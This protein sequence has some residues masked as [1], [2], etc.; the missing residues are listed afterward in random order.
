VCV[1][2]VENRPMFLW[3]NFREFYNLKF[4]KNRNTKGIITLAAM[5]KDIYYL[6]QAFYGSE[7][8]VLHLC[9]RHHFL[10]QTAPDNGIKVY[11]NASE[12][13][14]VLNGVS[15]GKLKNGDYRLAD[16]EK[17]QRGGTV[18]TIPGIQVNNVFFWK[19]TLR[20]GCNVVEVR[21]SRGLSKSMVIYQK[22]ADGP[23]PVDNTALVADLKS[24]N[25]DNPAVFIDR[26]VES[27]GPFYYDVDGSSDNTFD[28][29]PP[30]V[31]GAAWIAAR[32]LSEP[33]MK[34]DLSFRL[35]KDAAVYVLYSTG[36]FPK[37]TLRKPN[38]DTQKESAVLR[39]AIS[40]AGF[41][42][43]SVKTTWRG[44]DLVLAHCTLW[45]RSSRAG[46]TIT[47]PGHTLDYVILVKSK[48]Y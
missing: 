35:N 23:M 16:S 31:E 14:L 42:D 47:I 1:D 28:I 32:R 4:K 2:D 45:K 39:Q 29:L 7:Q 27:Q 46:E 41:R 22:P 40:A 20:P 3:W 25:P 24:S 6:F 5:P 15:Q 12:L 37:I 36:T 38:E 11:S 33:K 8:P 43:T 17:R 9:G 26:P 48:P 13:E 34:T 19:A 30:E 10:R 18:T 44:H 21:D